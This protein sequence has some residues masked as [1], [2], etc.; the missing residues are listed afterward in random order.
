MSFNSSFF[1][2]RYI[3]QDVYEPLRRLKERFDKVTRK[4][5]YDKYD[6]KDKSFRKSRLYQL[7]NE[8]SY[9]VDEIQR[10]PVYMRRKIL[11]D[12][13]DLV[14]SLENEQK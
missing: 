11:S 9:A 8:F 10:G 4:M 1:V 12:L 6:K 13:E 3:P 2:T 14:E 5:R 7:Q